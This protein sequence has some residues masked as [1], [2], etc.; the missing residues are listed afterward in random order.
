MLYKIKTFNQKWLLQE[1]VQ[2]VLIYIITAIEEYPFWRSFK[3]AQI[4]WKLHLDISLKQFLC[5]QGLQ[6]HPKILLVIF[7]NGQYYHAFPLLKI[8]QN[9][10]C[11]A[12]LALGSLRGPYSKQFQV[13]LLIQRCCSDSSFVHCCGNT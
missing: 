6:L 12:P 7:T 8:A 11:C 3:M 9:S 1:N 10:K 13:P 5:N 2:E 4:T